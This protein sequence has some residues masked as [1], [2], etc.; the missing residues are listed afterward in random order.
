MAINIPKALGARAATGLFSFVAF[1]ILFHSCTEY[2]APYEAGVRESRFGGGVSNEV[3]PGG[4]WVFTGPG[5]TIHRFPLAV[6]SL[7]MSASDAESSA[8][9]EDSRR[10]PPIEIDTSDGS[11]VKVDVSILYRIVEPY[12]V[13]TKIGPRRM[14]EDSAVIPKAGLAL[15]KNLGKLLAEDFYHE[16]KRVSRCLEARDELNAL[17]KD[18]GIAVDHV[19]VRQYSYEA[20]YQAQIEERK[21]RDQQVFTNKSIGEAAKEEALKKKIEAEGAANVSIEEQR[22]EAEVTKIR[23]EADLY[24][25]KKI[26]E[27]DMLVQVAEANGMQMVNSSYAQAGSDNLVALEMAKVLDGL[28]YIVL[29]DTKS[30]LN[31]LNVDEVIKMLGVK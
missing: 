23:A 19:L 11:K 24:R 30:G 14:F 8:S 26:S 2:V 16:S 6:Q 21:V 22:G 20:G 29:S 25:V 10:V 15:K 27:A 5:V 17:L 3:M 4:R 28:Q 13:M 31:P 12:S 7:E 9:Y 18:V 1:I